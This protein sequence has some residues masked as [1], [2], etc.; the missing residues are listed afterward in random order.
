MRTGKAPFEQAAC[1][2]EKRTICM[3]KHEEWYILNLL[4]FKKKI[5]KI[6]CFGDFNQLVKKMSDVVSTS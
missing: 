2:S 5:T 4:Q 1:V 3:V 6:T